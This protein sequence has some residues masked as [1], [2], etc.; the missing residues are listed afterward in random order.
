MFKVP[1]LQTPYNLSSQQ[2]KFQ[3]RFQLP[4]QR[5]LPGFSTENRMA[6]TEIPFSF[7]ESDRL[8][9]YQIKEPCAMRAFRI[10]TEPKRR[11]C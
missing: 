1:V 2:T 8:V 3:G 7:F 5:A 11:L 9:G 6:G 10:R 4:F